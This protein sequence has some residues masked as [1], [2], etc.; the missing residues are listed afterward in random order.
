MRRRGGYPESA[1]VGFSTVAD[2]VDMDMIYM[3]SISMTTSTGHRTPQAGYLIWNLSTKWRA[4][5]DR[6]MAPLG[7]THAQYVL[8]ASLFGASRSGA[9]PSQ[10][11]LAA[12]GGLEP[13]YVSRLVR[14]LEGEGLVTREVNADDPRAYLLKLTERGTEVVNDAMARVRALQE[15]LLA[16][17]GEPDDPR[18][19]ELE[20]S[21]RILLRHARDFDSTIIQED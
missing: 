6:A 19:V 1:R 12:F 17:L 15:Q 14:T 7:L 21:L 13:M 18:R 9:R 20:E 3:D 2:I 16:P 5:V 4:A 8:L 11:E 10:R